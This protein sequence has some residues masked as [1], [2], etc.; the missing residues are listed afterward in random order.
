MR[1]RLFRCGCGNNYYYDGE[2]RINCDPC[3]TAVTSK[4]EG[5]YL[6]HRNQRGQIVSKERVRTGPQR[7]YAALSGNA[8][9]TLGGL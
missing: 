4:V 2:H 6:V 9:M 8:P 1:P 7:A 5:D 3:N